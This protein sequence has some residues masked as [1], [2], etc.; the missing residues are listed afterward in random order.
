[1]RRPVHRGSAK[2]IAATAIVATATITTTSC[3][4]PKPASEA[5]GGDASAITV[6]REVDASAIALTTPPDAGPATVAI[7]DDIKDD[8]QAISVKDGPTVTLHTIGTAMIEVTLSKAMAPGKKLEIER[9]LTSTQ[10]NDAGS[11]ATVQHDAFEKGT[12]HLHSAAHGAKYTYR[13]RVGPTGTWSPNVTLQVPEPLTPPPGPTKLT[14]RADG[15]FVVRLAW[16][17]TAKSAAGYQVERKAQKGNEEWQLVA[18]LNPDVRS[19]EH[20]HRLP[21]EQVEYRVRAFNAV[22]LSASSPTALVILPEAGVSSARLPPPT[23]MNACI[24]PVKAA[25]K[26]S[27]GCNPDIDKITDG[28]E[29]LNVPSAGDSCRRR[30]IGE[31][32]GCTREFGAFDLQADIKAVP[33]YMDEGFP[34]L[35]AVAGAGQFAGAEIQTLRFGKGRYAIVDSAIFCGEFQP[36]PEDATVGAYEA[37]I[38]QCVPPFEV[39]QRDLAF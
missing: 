23:T 10:G 26:T 6:A 38:T 35:H 1:M 2:Y 19:L 4:K 9:E 11:A 15:A 16:E 39:C 21:K 5:L 8:T 31:Y 20:H 24:P 28:H 18:V 36:N 12:R 14:A 7:N 29:V 25:P 13:A 32:Q 17:A 37:D 34:L 3:T 33:G 22:G 30:L 27:G